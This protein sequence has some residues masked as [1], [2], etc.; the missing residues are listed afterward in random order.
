MRVALGKSSRI[1]SPSLRLF[2]L[3]TTLG[4]S[5]STSGTRWMA[6][7]GE[8][9]LT[10]DGA[11]GA[12]KE[13]RTFSGSLL[14]SNGVNVH[15][16]RHGADAAQLARISWNK[17]LD[18]KTLSWSKLEAKSQA[19]PSELAGAVSFSASAGHSLLRSLIHKPALGLP[20]VLMEVFHSLLETLQ[21]PTAEPEIIFN[22]LLQAKLET[23]TKELQATDQV[24]HRISFMHHLFQIMLT[25][26]KLQTSSMM[27]VL[28]R[29]R[30]RSR[31]WLL[32]VVNQILVRL[33]E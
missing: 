31:S 5:T 13:W 16:P 28:P 19:E 25:E 11:H 23:V 21:C 15:V 1:Y 18:F 26:N 29:K 27:Q 6:R 8:G 22:L 20:C 33:P 17:V 7:R 32:N 2:P 30:R 4:P 10:V 3:A 14:C 24:L 9:H 12:R